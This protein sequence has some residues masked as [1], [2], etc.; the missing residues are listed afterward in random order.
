MSDDALGTIDDDEVDFL[1]R[2]I[3]AQHGE[4]AALAAEHHLDQLLETDSPRCETWIAVVDAIHMI[5]CRERSSQRTGAAW[6]TR[7]PRFP[8]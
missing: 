8:Q 5:R 7:Q 4:A 6:R 3:I 2:T 1:A